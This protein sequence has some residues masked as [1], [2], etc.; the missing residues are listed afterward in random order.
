M[1]I[2]RAWPTAMFRACVVFALVLTLASCDDNVPSIRTS[3][4]INSTDWIENIQ[5]CTMSIRSGKLSFDD[6]AQAYVN[7]GSIYYDLGKY[8]LAVHDFTEAISIDP[9]IPNTFNIRGFAYHH[10]GE[11]ELAARDYHAEIVLDEN[12]APAYANLGYNYRSLGLH[13]DAIAEYN[14]AISIEP[15]YALAYKRRGDSYLLTDRFDLA[16][17]DYTRAIELEP[18]YAAAYGMRG[19]AQAY[20]GDVESAVGDWEREMAI[21]GADRVC[22]WQEWLQRNGGHYNGPVDGVYSDEMRVGLFACA[23]DYDCL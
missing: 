9:N 22:W 3:D 20:L 8:I 14:N 16:R 11:Y 18:N 2:L 17:H 13:E 21:L 4:C 23:R 15:T 7:R 5:A 12:F 1:R 19:L 6:L 10:L